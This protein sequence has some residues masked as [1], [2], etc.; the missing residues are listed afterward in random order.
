M[1]SNKLILG[2]VFGLLVLSIGTFSI[3]DAFGAIDSKGKEFVITFNPN[4]GNRANN[5]QLH[6]E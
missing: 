6:I 1:R 2:V 5:V 4:N 3:T